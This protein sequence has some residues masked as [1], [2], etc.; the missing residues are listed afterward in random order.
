[1][2]PGGHWPPSWVWAL[3]VAAALWEFV[4]AGRKRLG[5]R[6]QLDTT[7]RDSAASFSTMTPHAVRSDRGPAEILVILDHDGERS[8]LPRT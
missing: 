2:C 3:P 6:V 8:H 5:Y 7:F 1:M 4:L